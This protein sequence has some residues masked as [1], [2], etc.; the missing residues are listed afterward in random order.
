MPKHNQRIY[1]DYCHASCVH[2]YSLTTVP[3]VQKK[4][5]AKK[6]MNGNHQWVSSNALAHHVCG[7]LSRSTSRPLIIGLHRLLVGYKRGPSRMGMSSYILAWYFSGAMTSCRRWAKS[8][9]RKK[10]TRSSKLDSLLAASLGALVRRFPLSIGR[11]VA[12]KG[13]PGRSYGGLKG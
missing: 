7:P 9:N 12:A 3:E 8:K 4:K 6:S 2:T 5:G 1:G 11:V 13:G 10:K